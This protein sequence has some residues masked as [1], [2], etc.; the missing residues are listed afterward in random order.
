MWNVQGVDVGRAGA[1]RSRSKSSR[2]G[3]EEKM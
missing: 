2:R 3:K 1:S